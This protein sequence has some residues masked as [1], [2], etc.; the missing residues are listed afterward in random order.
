LVLAAP[1]R[2]LGGFPLGEVAGDFDVPDEVAC[3]VAERI[4]DDVG[5]IAAPVLADPPALS[6]NLPSLAAVA[7]A[8]AGNPFARSSSV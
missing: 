4:D 3:G 5:P 8:F 7:R 6:S 2:R 1:E